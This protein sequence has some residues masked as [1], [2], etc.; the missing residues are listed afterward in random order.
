MPFAVTG[1]EKMSG[2]HA[3]AIS[4]SISWFSVNQVLRRRCDVLRW[5]GNA[6][7]QHAQRGRRRRRAEAVG[8]LLLAAGRAGAEKTARIRKWG[9]VREMV[10]Q[11]VRNR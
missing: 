7:D 8:G 3:A 2:A 10:S 5:I 9:Q 6:L 1:Q 11:R 4:D